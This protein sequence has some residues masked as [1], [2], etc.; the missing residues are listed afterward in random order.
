MTPMNAPRKLALY[1]ALLTG[2]LAASVAAG[3]ALEPTGLATAEPAPAEHG[4]GM[5][6]G[7]VPGLATTD[8]GLRLV[9]DT[10]TAPVH[11]SVAY[12]FR[13][14]GEDGVVTAFDVSHTKQMHV[15]VVRRDFAGFQ[16]LHPDIAVDGSWELDLSIPDAG[17]YR[18]FADFVTD[19][20]KHTLATDLFV[21]G[22]FRPAPLRVPSRTADAGDGYTV[23][24]TG[25]AHVGQ[26]STLQF[27]VRHEGD[28]VEELQDY[29]GARGH[30][31]ALRDGDLAY[32][33]VHADEERLSFEAEFPSEGDYRLFLQFRDRDEVRTAAFTIH[34]EEAK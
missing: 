8:D 5:D 27:V 20:D 23:E 16:H 25:D 10:D 19:G 11:S 26:E 3:S 34:A 29:L 15:I 28:I 4:G 6:P 33:H 31:V 7:M 21:G 14:E 1:A 18:V 17:S 9:A 32:L 2:V 22:D 24:L 13:I 12:R 30:L